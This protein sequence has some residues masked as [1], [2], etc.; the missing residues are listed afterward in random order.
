M[1][2]MNT[3][4]HDPKQKSKAR[5][6]RTGFV[7]TIIPLNIRQIIANNLRMLPLVAIN[8]NHWNAALMFIAP[9]RGTGQGRRGTPH[10]KQNQTQLPPPVAISPFVAQL[11]LCYIHKYQPV[12]RPILNDNHCAS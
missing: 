9:Q 1:Y 11:R 5:E 6:S 4:K 7:N 12:L 8:I 2:I 3:H 10:Q